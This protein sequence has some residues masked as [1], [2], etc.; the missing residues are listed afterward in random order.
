[1]HKLIDAD[2][3]FDRRAIHARAKALHNAAIERGD[4]GEAATFEHWSAYCW[5]VARDQH[6]AAAPLRMAAAAR[7]IMKGSGD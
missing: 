5:R 7:A 6:E 4:T 3:E 2:G 1:M